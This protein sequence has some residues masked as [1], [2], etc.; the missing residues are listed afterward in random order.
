M[1]CTWLIWLLALIVGFGL[2][3]GSHTWTL[4]LEGEAYV[5]A[6]FFALLLPIELFRQRPGT[7]PGSRYGRAVLLNLQANLLVLIVLAIAATYEAIEVI[8]QVK[9]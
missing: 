5:L 1:R 6:T 3:L 7:T 9:G 8:L 4:L 2:M